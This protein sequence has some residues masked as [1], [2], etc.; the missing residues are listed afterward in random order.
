MTKELM[1]IKLGQN[2]TISDEFLKIRKA[3]P[4][5]LIE[6]SK[7]RSARE[8]FLLRERM[9]ADINKKARDSIN[10][11]KERA[12]ITDEN[13]KSYS[14]NYLEGKKLERELKKGGLVLD[15]KIDGI[16]MALLADVP[17]K[18]LVEKKAKARKMEA[19]YNKQLKKGA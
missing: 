8:E 16:M 7:C 5:Q 19:E 17:G 10:A 6:L 14:V 9:Q 3:M 15:N 4:E 11:Y 18:N 13:G 1:P 2:A 12:F